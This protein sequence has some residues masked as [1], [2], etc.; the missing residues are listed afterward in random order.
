MRQRVSGRRGCGGQGADLRAQQ[1]LAAAASD[2]GPHALSS[3]SHSTHFK[4]TASHL[5]AQ[6]AAVKAVEGHGGVQSF[7]ACP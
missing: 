1:G 4:C 6:R 2:W 5:G 3:P 7:S